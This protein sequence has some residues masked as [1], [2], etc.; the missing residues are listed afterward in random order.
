MC[1]WWQRKR[2]SR[3]RHRISVVGHSVVIHDR[4]ATGHQTSVV[5]VT[6]FAEGHAVVAKGEDSESSSVSWCDLNGHSVLL[7]SYISVDPA[8]DLVESIDMVMPAILAIARRAVAQP[9]KPSLLAA[10]T[11]AVALFALGAAV[12]LGAVQMTVKSLPPCAVAPA[13]DPWAKGREDL[14]DML[15]KRLLEERAR[16]SQPATVPPTKAPNPLVDMVPTA[17]Q[18]PPAAGSPS[19]PPA[20]QAPQP[21]PTGAQQGAPKTGT[22]VPLE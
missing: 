1:Q 6:T 2:V 18:P 19:M 8:R 20:V 7:F 12:A 3:M 17:Q 5:P 13:A 10:G 16:P 9:R 15:R 21:P 4:S 11:V 22:F 14:A